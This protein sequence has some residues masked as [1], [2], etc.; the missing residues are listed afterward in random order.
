[1]ERPSVKACQ[2]LL[3]PSFTMKALLST[4][5]L[6]QLCSTAAAAAVVGPP[7]CSQFDKRAA[8]TLAVH[9][10]GKYHRHG[11]KFRMDISKKLS[12]AHVEQ[13]GEP[14]AGFSLV[15]EQAGGAP[16]LP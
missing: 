5:L 3:W 6:L 14:G 12:G 11:Y 8:S 4:L 15:C 16:S 1:M 9:H 13:V 2:L 10:I 7:R